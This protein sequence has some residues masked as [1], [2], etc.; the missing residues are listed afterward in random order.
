[1]TD[2]PAMKGVIPYLNVKGAGD[3]ADFYRRAF[4]AEEFQ[5]MPAEDG[6]RFM[7]IHLLI[8]GGS[9]MLS[10]VFPEHGFDWQPST[11]FTMQL[12]VDDIDSWWKRA[13]DAGAEV[14]MPVAVM[15]WGDRYGTLRDPFGVNWA[16][17]EP[18]G[19]PAA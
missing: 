18:A 12:V 13:V 7:H 9:L 19:Q 8:N 4:G 3:A 10:D 6:K 1:M 17:N 16:L 5:R 14:N 2:T 15:F 11:S